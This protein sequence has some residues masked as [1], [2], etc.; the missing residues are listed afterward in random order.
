MTEKREPYGDGKYAKVIKV[1]PLQ[2]KWQ[3]PYCSFVQVNES[4]G[5]PNGENVVV[6]RKCN[7]L[8]ILR[9]ERREE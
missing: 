1:V 8:S 9:L 6:C 3:C 2:I 5:L 7:K 4:F